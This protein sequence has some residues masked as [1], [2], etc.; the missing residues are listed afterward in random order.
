[1]P[2]FHRALYGYAADR[3]RRPSFR[4]LSIS[5]RLHSSP[6][7][8]MVGPGTVRLRHFCPSAYY[9]FLANFPRRIGTFGDDEE[10]YREV[11]YND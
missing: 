3:D 2:G 1:M 10:V 11:C 6:A 7:G 4:A 9:V 5:R 8:A